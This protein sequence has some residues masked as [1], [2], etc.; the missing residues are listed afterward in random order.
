MSESNGLTTKQL[1]ERMD[2]RDELFAEILVEQ[3]KTN[4]ILAQSQL[5]LVEVLD[6]HGTTLSRIEERMGLGEDPGPLDIA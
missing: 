3:R 2:Q 6:R 5:A 4:R 1:L